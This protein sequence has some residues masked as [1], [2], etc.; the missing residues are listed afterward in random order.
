MP[1][2][3]TP[4]GLG[5]RRVGTPGHDAAEADST[6]AE[7]AAVAVGLVSRLNPT[8]P[9]HEGRV[10]EFWQALLDAAIDQGAEPPGNG[11]G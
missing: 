3:L 6:P 5:Q 7:L 1:A 4:T 8:H 2:P 10:A 11:E 9:D